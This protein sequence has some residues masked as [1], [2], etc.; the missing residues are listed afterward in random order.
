MY[1]VWEHR[2][3]AAPKELE[4]VRRI[5]TKKGFTNIVVQVKTKACALHPK[6]ERAD[7]RKGAWE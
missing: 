4:L 6:G 3:Y 7:G 5:Y 2:F 1:C